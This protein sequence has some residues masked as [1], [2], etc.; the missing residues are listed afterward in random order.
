MWPSAWFCS[1]TANI[2][3]TWALP[4]YVLTLTSFP[5][6]CIGMFFKEK[7]RRVMLWITSLSVSRPVEEKF[8]LVCLCYAAQG[9][10]TAFCPPNMNVYHP[11]KAKLPR[12]LRFFGDSRLGTM[13]W[14][15][16]LLSCFSCFFGNAIF[17]SLFCPVIFPSTK[18][19]WS[20][21]SDQMEFSVRS[22]VWSKIKSFTSWTIYLFL[23]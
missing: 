12:T 15:E 11:D 1:N 5:L 16:V 20:A 22:G 3:C 23:L 19:L 8:L 10:N 18:T 17:C 9:C 4:V 21:D 14:E 7:E 13:S 6:L 2:I